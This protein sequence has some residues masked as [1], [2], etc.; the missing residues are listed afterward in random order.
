MLLELI[1]LHFLRPHLAGTLTLANTEFRYCEGTWG[2]CA[3]VST[4]CTAVLISSASMKP[5]ASRKVCNQTS[6]SFLL[7]ACAVVYCQ[8]WIFTII[9]AVVLGNSWLVMLVDAVQR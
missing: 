9:R 1:D 4:C 8:L 6:T 2:K 7:P 3:M 5:V